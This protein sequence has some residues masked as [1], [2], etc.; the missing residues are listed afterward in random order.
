MTDTAKTAT[1]RVMLT[2]EQAAEAL[3]IGRT[4][5]YALIKSG[6]LE[7]VRIGRLRRI[8]ADAINAYT[9]RLIATQTGA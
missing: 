5:I 2:A 4:T 9:A 6:D 8:P 7:S 1:P 3:G